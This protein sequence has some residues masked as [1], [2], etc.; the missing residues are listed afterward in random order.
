M[1]LKAA[2]ALKVSENYFRADTQRHLASCVCP[3]CLAA[4]SA[5][6]RAVDTACAVRKLSCTVINRCTIVNKV[7]LE[8]FLDLEPFAAQVKR[9]PRTVRRWLRCAPDGLPYTRIGNRILIHVPTAR[10][11]DECDR[12]AQH[13]RAAPRLARR[14]R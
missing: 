3:T 8:D 12:Y 7:L 13:R 6:C 5:E 9:N 2:L 14:A 10:V 11:V 1:P 4:L